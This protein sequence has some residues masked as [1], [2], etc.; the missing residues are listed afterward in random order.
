[1]ALGEFR[2]NL[3]DITGV[4]AAETHAHGLRLQASE[5]DTDRLKGKFAAT[6]A[7]KSPFHD[8]DHVSDAHAREAVQVSEDLAR[9]RIDKMSG[10]DNNTRMQRVNG[11]RQESAQ[12]NLRRRAKRSFND[13]IFFSML[14]QNIDALQKQVAGLEEGLR[15]RYGEN[16]A[17][18]IAAKYLDEET[19]QRRPGES[20]E[21]YRA[22]IAEEIQKKIEAGEINPDDPQIAEWAKT[23]KDLHEARDQAIEHIAKDAGKMVAS[24][25]LENQESGHML[26]A[27][28][29]VAATAKGDVQNAFV[30]ASKDMSQDGDAAS[31]LGALA[32]FAEAGLEITTPTQTK[33]PAETPTPE[34]PKI[35]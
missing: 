12:D 24:G 20:D 8:E 19:A 23:R 10:S 28:D 22:R 34:T 26:Q 7:A 3:S 33:A 32:G 29:Q 15:E 14:Q 11:S 13:Q 1:M 4:T 21:E 18:V 16:F 17:E 2:E 31:G 25:E 30:K 35:G 5:K 9:E 6:D 27:E